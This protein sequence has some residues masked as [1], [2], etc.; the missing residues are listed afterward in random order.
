MANARPASALLTCTYVTVSQF[1]LSE[2]ANVSTILNANTDVALY[3]FHFAGNSMSA[4]HLR[5][6]SKLRHE[7]VASKLTTNWYM[8]CMVCYS[9]VLRFSFALLHG[10]I[11]ALLP[12]YYGR[13]TL[14]EANLSSACCYRVM[15]VSIRYSRSGIL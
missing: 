12:I 14:T 10:P 15:L 13:T 11:L 9:A 7:A 5:G 8:L 6:L 1:L 3:G 4:V 2:I